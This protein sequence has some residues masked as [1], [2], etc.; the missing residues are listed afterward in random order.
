MDITEPLIYECMEECYTNLKASH[1]ELGNATAKIFDSYSISSNPSINYL[2][3]ECL[4]KKQSI[5]YV[6]KI[7]NRVMIAIVLVLIIKDVG[8][9]LTGK[10]ENPFDNLKIFELDCLT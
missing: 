6:K 10:E 4:G 2:I 5:E 7:T 9:E 1:S 3:H 8:S